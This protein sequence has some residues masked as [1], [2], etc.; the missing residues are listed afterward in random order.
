MGHRLTGPFFNSNLPSSSAAS[1]RALSCPWLN[2]GRLEQQ[3]LLE[4][5]LDTR[6][7]SSKLYQGR[8]NGHEPHD[9]LLDLGTFL[10][11]VH[12]LALLKRSIKVMGSSGEA[13]KP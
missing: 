12:A 4:I 2:M 8:I 7:K 11:I 9:R 13:S 3:R 5:D 10:Q 6:D 1:S